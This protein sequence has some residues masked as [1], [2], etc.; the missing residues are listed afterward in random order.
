MS[1]TPSWAAP[2]PP[3]PTYSLPLP[4]L[5]LPTL[6]F[7]TPQ[8]PHPHRPRSIPPFLQNQLGGHHYVLSYCWR[9]RLRTLK[10]GF[11]GS[12][13]LVLFDIF[14]VLSYLYLLNRFSSLPLDNT[15]CHVLSSRYPRPHLVFACTGRMALCT[16]ITVACMTS[17]SIPHW[18]SPVSVRFPNTR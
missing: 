11:F 17:S 18:F 10:K 2:V 3:K 4:S 1:P 14:D 12:L 9:C 5:E 6:V 7:P 13:S 16:S 15:Q 8:Q